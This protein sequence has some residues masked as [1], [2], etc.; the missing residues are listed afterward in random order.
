MG[1]DLLLKN[2]YQEERLAIKVQHRLPIEPFANW[3][4][5]QTEVFGN[6]DAMA[7]AMGED[8]I[9]L[10]KIKNRKYDTVDIDRVDSILCKEGGTHLRELYP[11]IYEE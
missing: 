7:F 10:G 11:E 1:T 3:L 6:I 4:G 5:E 9:W 2:V 8:S